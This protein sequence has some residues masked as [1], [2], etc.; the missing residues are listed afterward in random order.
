MVPMWLNWSVA[1]LIA[2]LQLLDIYRLGNLL[3]LLLFNFFT[4]L[5]FSF[6]R[7]ESFIY[8]HHCKEFEA[9]TLVSMRVQ[10]QSPV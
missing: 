8:K 9:I 1:T 5:C 2:T 10:R 4:N 7:Y 6:T 3:L